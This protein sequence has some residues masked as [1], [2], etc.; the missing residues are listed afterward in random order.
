MIIIVGLTL[1]W[2]SAFFVRNTRYINM[3]ATF[4][5]SAGSLL[6]A[7]LSATALLNGST[8]HFTLPVNMIAGNLSFGLS[9]L[10]SFF[11]FVIAL[12]SVLTTV[13]APKYLEHY[14]SSSAALKGHWFFYTVLVVSM[15]GVVTS[16]DAVAFLICW[17]LMSLSSFFLVAFN[18]EKKE[19][20]KAA[21]MYLVFTHIGTAFL[22]VMFALLAS[23][24]G[25]FSFDSFK[26]ASGDISPAAGSVIFIFS[27]IGFGTKAGLV[28]FHV[29]L[30]KAHPAAP[31]HVSALMSAVM[32]KTPVY[33]I[34]MVLSFL[35]TPLSWWGWIL[36][37]AGVGSGLFGIVMATMQKDLKSLLAYSSVENIGIISLGIGIGVIGMS[38]Q[39]EL[40]MTFG[41]IGSLLHVLN[42]SLFKS[43]LFLGAGSVQHATGSLAIESMGGLIKK[44]PVTG[45]TF[46]IGS[47]AIAG[48]PPLNGFLG[49]FLLYS[50]SFR[51]LMATPL[52]NALFAIVVIGGLSLIGALAVFCFTKV[53]SIVFLGEPR[54]NRA[55]KASENT[56]FMTVPMIILALLCILIAL[57]P[58]PFITAI[59]GAAGSV[60]GIFSDQILHEIITPLTHIQGITVALVALVG[61]L[62]LFRF[63]LMRKRTVEVTETW[64]CGYGEV[65]AS[66][67]YTASSFSQPLTS[68][69]DPVLVS[70]STHVGTKDPFPKQIHVQVDFFD[71]FMDKVFSPGYRSMRK[72][73]KKLIVIQHGNVHIYV[74][75]IIIAL[76]GVLA[77]SL[78]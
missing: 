24:S 68:F 2:L 46:L 66:M 64:G 63:L 40:L 9:P 75:Y 18:N 55:R 13:Y 60:T 35:N 15:M 25:S 77:W 61:I 50:V 3:A 31:S 52:L 12:I 71:F 14:K 51:H 56:P 7:L 44:M 16:R 59:A 62:F 21:W 28:P 22:L 73:M 37:L 5:I 54:S 20:R 1:I 47:A 17:E 76:L 48:L 78:V 19:V 8:A 38:L 49:E 32:I 65:N 58:Q 45:L 30:P 33:G 26:A 36:L 43:L 69:L 72:H 11:L 53:V 10:S 74:L 23:G 6:A 39:N 4:S 70:K 34:I 67:Q 41:F 42:H 27:L 29:W 57:L